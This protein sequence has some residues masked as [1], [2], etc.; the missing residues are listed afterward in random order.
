MIER[1][2][3]VRKTR[4]FGADHQVTLISAS[5]LAISLSNSGENAE[6]EQILR[7][8]VALSRR[9]LGPTHDF[10]THVTELLPVSS[11]EA[12][13]LSLTGVTIF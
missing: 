10:T 2:V 13:S 12:S 8:T 4:L 3:L 5:N 1:E 9:A 7:D 11:G 6:C